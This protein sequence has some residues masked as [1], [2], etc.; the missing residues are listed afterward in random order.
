M[1]K[2][3]YRKNVMKPTD[4]DMFGNEGT[5]YPH[6][7]FMIF[8]SFNKDIAFEDLKWLEGTEENW[9]GMRIS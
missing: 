5:F 7:K 3:W 2:E 8:L 1:D 6:E 9:R 4:T